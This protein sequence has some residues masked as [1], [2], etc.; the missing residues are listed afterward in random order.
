[1]RKEL[2]RAYAFGERDSTGLTIKPVAEG[3]LQYV[4]RVTSRDPRLW[5]DR[6]TTLIDPRA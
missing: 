1:M 6:T 2:C 4:L 3:E 5:D